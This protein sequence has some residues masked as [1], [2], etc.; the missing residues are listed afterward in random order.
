M[1][2]NDQIWADYGEAIC[3]AW[4]VTFYDQAVCTQDI[5]ELGI[6]DSYTQAHGNCA[7]WSALTMDYGYYWPENFR[8]WVR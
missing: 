3:G 1:A 7:G 6:S 2:C 8:I 4:V 5:F